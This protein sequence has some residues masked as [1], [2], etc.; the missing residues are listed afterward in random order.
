MATQT[1]LQTLAALE[2]EVTVNDNP[3]LF[4]QLLM[5]NGAMVIGLVSVPDYQ[6]GLT[7]GFEKGIA[8]EDPV[9]IDVIEQAG[10]LATTSR[11]VF[12]SST[13]QR[14][15]WVTKPIAFNVIGGVKQEGVDEPKFTGSDGDDFFR[16]YR[17]N[18]ES[19]RVRVSAAQAGLI[20]PK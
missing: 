2:R 19:R 15:I 6:L 4:V 11:P 14:N 16:V 12:L 3:M 9:R 10:Q 1:R 20:L 8:I 18:L 5:S 17:Q 13:D 7:A